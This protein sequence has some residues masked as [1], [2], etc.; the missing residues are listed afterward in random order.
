MS[1]DPLRFRAAWVVAAATGFWVLALGLTS[2]LAWGG[3]AIIAYAPDYAFAGLAAWGLALGLGFGFLPRLSFKKDTSAPPLP[4]GEHPRL[5]AFVREI[6]AKAGAP[7][8]DALYVFHEANAF[9]GLRRGRL[10]AKRE[11]VVGI[12]LPLLAVLTESESRAVLA[13]EM[14]HHIGGDVALGPWVHRTRRAIAR[15]VDRLEGSSFWLHLP[16]VAYAELFLKTSARISRAQEFAA[17]AL[18]AKIAG[19][20]ATASALRKTDVIASAWGTFFRSEVVPLLATG[21]LPPLLEGWNRYWRAAQTPH[22]P[23]FEALQGALSTDALLG[24]EDTHPPL[25]ERIA[26]L[27]DPAALPDGAGPSLSLLDDVRQVEERVLRDLVRDDAKLTSIAW[28]AVADE[29]WLPLWREAV[30]AS[31]S[32][33]A[34]LDI[35]GLPAA[36]AQWEPLAEATRRGPA[37]A[38]REAERRRVIRLVSTWF[39]VALADR[40]W[41]IEAPP[42]LAVTAT[43]DGRS[44]QPFVM[45]TEMAATPDAAAWSRTCAEHQL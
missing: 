45:V 30:A 33:L 20:G 2:L 26:A 40:G 13:H 18:S 38:S 11:S 8:P 34:R 24:D 22:T 23:A 16:F 9:A 42:G 25:P 15:A 37:V 36:L 7:A 27:G 1:R 29:V 44:L 5:Q 17:D 35:S 28:D 19:P 43:R 6:A 12:G 14:G 31:R 41:T 3:Y 4:P 21:R 10:L 39:A 32:A